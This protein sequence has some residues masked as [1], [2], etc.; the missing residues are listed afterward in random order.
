MRR[1]AARRPILALCA[2]GLALVLTVLVQT[3]LSAAVGISDFS[4]RWE[5]EQVIVSW[6]TAQDKDFAR[7]D[8][9]RS[10]SSDGDYGKIGELPVQ[11]PGRLID[12][13]YV[14]T[15]TNNLTPNKTYYYKLELFY[16]DNTSDYD[17]PVAAD[18]STPTPTSTNTETPT[19]TCTPT[20]TN[21]G[22]PPTNTPTPTTTQV[23][24][25]STPSPTLT[26]TRTRPA[27][28]LDPYS[29]D[30][31]DAAGAE[32]P[33]ADLPLPTRSAMLNTTGA[34]A[35][36][37]FAEPLVLDEPTPPMEEARLAPATITPRSTRA[38]LLVKPKPRPSAVEN[39][40]RPA[41]LMLGLTAA[42][43]QDLGVFLGALVLT[44]LAGAEFLVLVGMLF[45]YL[46]RYP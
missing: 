35:T 19:S 15:D 9:L 7:F 13:V 44:S 4:A 41:Q 21:T 17:G 34:A 30:I 37:D 25:A 5:D 46:R 29:T 2:V 12:A 18:P 31:A 6:T 45:W 8:V 32:D 11:N 27:P 14:F 23:Q 10:D 38:A 36:P 24:A 43:R 20:A 40:A 3:R 16:L 42:Q 26:R 1:L 22:A 39:S 28:T 33:A